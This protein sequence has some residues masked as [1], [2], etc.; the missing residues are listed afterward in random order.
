MSHVGMTHKTRLGFKPPCNLMECYK[1][2]CRRD[3]FLSRDR[4]Y[5]E[6]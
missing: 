1:H 5:M 2:P 3:R 6:T 4:Q